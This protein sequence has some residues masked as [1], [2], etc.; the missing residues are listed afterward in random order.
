MGHESQERIEG[1]ETT[2][3]RRRYD[4]EKKKI[5]NHIYVSVYSL[6]ISSTYFS[7]Y[8]SS[9]IIYIL[10]NYIYIIFKSFV[11]SNLLC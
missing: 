1:F 5:C 11:A 4:D 3:E 6:F 2:P 9:Y 10:Y 8:I 7:K